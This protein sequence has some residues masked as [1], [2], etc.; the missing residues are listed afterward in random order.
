MKL[1]QR[2]L[3]DP[4]C[5]RSGRWVGQED[6]AACD[7]FNLSHATLAEA[8]SNSDPTRRAADSHPEE[9]QKFEDEYLDGITLAMNRPHDLVMAG[10]GHGTFQGIEP[11]DSDD[12]QPPAKKPKKKRSSHKRSKSLVRD[13]GSN[14]PYE[15]EWEAMEPRR[16]SEMRSIRAVQDPAIYGNITKKS[17]SPGQG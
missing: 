11:A 12:H 2:G 6:E 7:A 4:D 17:L 16:K 1:V 14:D 15:M 9:A 13:A 5:T 3:F 10:E 8:V